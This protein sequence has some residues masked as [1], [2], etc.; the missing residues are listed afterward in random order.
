MVAAV[1]RMVAHGAT[2]VSLNVSERRLEPGV[3]PCRFRC[4]RPLSV[5]VMAKS[6]LPGVAKTRLCPPCTPEEAA[7]IAQ[8]ALC[9]TLEAALGCGHRVI[10]ALA[11]PPGPWLPD[12]VVVV[13]QVAGTFNERL[14]A[15]WSHLPA[16]G[17]QI[18][19][20]TPQCT[21]ELLERALM[22]VN[23][24]GSAL[25]PTT[26]GGWWLLGLDRPTPSMFDA[27]AMSTPTT[28]AAQL[29]RLQALGFE[30]VILPALTDI[31]TWSTACE[32]A[33]I[34]PGSRTAKAVERTSVI[35]AALR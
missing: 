30:P 20:D 1:T 11:G 2:R 26:D 10:L 35:S 28:G 21:A 33:A 15:A 6:P 19:M 31:D 22:A 17:V 34:T 29:L 3:P 14:D 24:A 27:I 23:D 8:A 13:A 12:G 5:L 32:V 25:G 7:S 16:G 18:G 4:V 9:D